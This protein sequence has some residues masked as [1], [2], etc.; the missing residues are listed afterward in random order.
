[1]AQNSNSAEIYPVLHTTSDIAGNVEQAEVAFEQGVDGLFLIDHH[2][3]DPRSLI[4]TYDAVRDEF[5]EFFIGLNMLGYDVSDALRKIIIDSKSTFSPDGLWSDYDEDPKMSKDR[6]YG[7]NVKIFGG[8]AFK[9][10]PTYTNDPEAAARLAA[11]APDWIDV[12]T[13]SGPKTGQAAPLEKLK[14]MKAAIPEGRELAVAS[15]VDMSNI[16][17]VREVVDKILLASSV[18]KSDGVFDKNKLREITEAAHQ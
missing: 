13:T 6:N 14:A 1:M 5:P 18:E 2:T 3:A 8:I 10:T 17:E 4:E 9:Y 16:A 11:A 12:I 7:R 15:G